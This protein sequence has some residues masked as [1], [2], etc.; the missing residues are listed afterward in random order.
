MYIA[1]IKYSTVRTNFI[2]LIT[3]YYPPTSKKKGKKDS[4]TGIA[5]TWYTS[6]FPHLFYTLNKGLYRIKSYEILYN[7]KFPSFQKAAEYF[8]ISKNLSQFPYRLK[9][10]YI[11]R[12]YCLRTLRYNYSNIFLQEFV[13]YKWIYSKPK[14]TNIQF[15]F[16]L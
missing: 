11:I 13:E 6:P 8:P 4:A 2:T 5:Y 9:W 3:F 12:Q 15:M 1:S 14:I 16:L 7:K 10:R